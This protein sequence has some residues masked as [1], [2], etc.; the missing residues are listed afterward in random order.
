MS[1]QKRLAVAAVQDSKSKD[2]M[3]QLEKNLKDEDI[4]KKYPAKKK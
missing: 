1:G 3:S 4:G 2:T